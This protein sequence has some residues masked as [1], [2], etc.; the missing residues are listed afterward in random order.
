MVLNL[1]KYYQ[2]NE[3][4]EENKDEKSDEIESNCLSVNQIYQ[5]H[6]KDNVLCEKCFMM[7]S[8]HKLS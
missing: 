1:I 4:V 6:Q 7:L 2:T 3:Q 8:I 5:I